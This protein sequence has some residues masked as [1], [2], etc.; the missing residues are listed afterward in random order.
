MRGRLAVAQGGTPK[1]LPPWSGR[2]YPTRVTRRTRPPE[3]ELAALV[4]AARK[5]TTAAVRRAAFEALTRRDPAA[6]EPVALA[7]AEARSGPQLAAAT[8]FLLTRDTRPARLAL[9][10]LAGRAT[11]D[12]SAVRRALGAMR[13]A[14]FEEALLA[15]VDGCVEALAPLAAVGSPELTPAP[16][17]HHHRAEAVLAAWSSRTRAPLSAARLRALAGRADAACVALELLCER[18]A[19]GALPRARALLDHPLLW[20]RHRAAKLLLARGDEGDRVRV[21][22]MLRDPCLDIG[23]LAVTAVSRGDAATVVDALLAV[24]DDGTVAS[25]LRATAGRLGFEARRFDESQTRRLASLANVSDVSLHWVGTEAVAHLPPEEAFERGA[26]LVPPDCAAPGTTAEFAQRADRMLRALVSS[27]AAL[28][29]RWGPLLT[30]VIRAPVGAWGLQC[31][32][33]HRACEL[34]ARLAWGPA[35]AALTSLAETAQ[36]CHLCRGAALRALG[37]F[38]EGA[39]LAVLGAAAQEADGTLCDPA[40]ASLEAIDDPAAIPW[41][42]RAAEATPHPS[43]RATIERLI[44]RLARAR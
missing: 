24:I 33:K 30:E 29:P 15:A 20:L 35:L 37:A 44:A 41:L 21:A 10:L 43:R 2:C 31:Q 19:E 40:F 28:D 38:R 18:D 26:P 22:A 5:G 25:P 42:S 36:W 17:L 11:Q 3:G 34:L 23:D 7:W 14:A 39:P 32:P 4:T 27:G 8:A 1:R 12:T 16:L 13:G 9:L 6:A